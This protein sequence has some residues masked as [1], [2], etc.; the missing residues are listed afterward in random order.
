MPGIGLYT[1]IFVRLLP[2]SAG[3]QTMCHEF[4]RDFSLSAMAYWIVSRQ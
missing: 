2:F 4:V 3:I 1:V